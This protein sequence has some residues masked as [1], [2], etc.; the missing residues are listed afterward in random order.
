[1]H[2]NTHYTVMLKQAG[3][4]SSGESEWFYLTMRLHIIITK[5]K[6]LYDD[7]TIFAYYD[8]TLGKQHN[9]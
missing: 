7:F 9:R 6:N 8:S 1:M 5:K 4:S 2:F 3:Y